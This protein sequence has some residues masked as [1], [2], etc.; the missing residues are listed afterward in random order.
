MKTLI[1]MRH[2]KS[3]WEYQ[4]SDKDRP[5]KER[6]INDAHMVGNRYKTNA[7]D[8]DA[9]F[10]SP[11]CRALHTAM[12]AL[13]EFDFPLEKF[14]VTEELYDFSGSSVA[15]FV[16]DLDDGLQKVII[17]GHNYAFTNIANQMGSVS[18]DNVPT[19]GLVQIS[20]NVNSWR[21]VDRGKTDQVLFPKQL[22]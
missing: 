19:A 17:F 13:R 4:V 9:A 14:E 12:I 8:L 1:L 2:G 3:S 20:F 21:S 7:Q 18:I 16:K 11:A 5:L 10:S 22:R 15:D 6:G